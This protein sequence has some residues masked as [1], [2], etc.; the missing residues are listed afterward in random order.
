MASSHPSTT[1]LFVNLPP[2][3]FIG[4]NLISFNSS[5]QFHGIKNVPPGL[6]FIYT[7]ADATLSMRNGIWLTIAPHQ[8]HITLKWTPEDE[9][10]VV[11]PESIAAPPR[12]LIDYQTLASASSNAADRAS[13]STAAAASPDDFTSLSSHIT[14]ALITRILTQNTISSISTAPRDS[15]IAGLP[16]IDA[17]VYPD[18]TLGFLDID[19]Q[20]T[21]NKDDVGAIRTERARDRSWYLGYLMDKAGEGLDVNH[22]TNGI[23]E[24]QR[25]RRQRGAEFLLGELQFSF[26][27]VMMLANYSCL[28][29]WKRLLSVLLTCKT[30]LGEI[31]GYFVEVLDM[32]AL[33][34][35]HVDDVEG[36]LFELRDEVGSQW[37]RLLV[38]KFS[39]NVKEFGGRRLKKR[40]EEFEKLMREEFDWQE[41][42]SVVRR[43]MLEMED[44]ERVEVAMDGAD[45]DE[46]K[47]EYAP[48]VVE[49]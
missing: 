19:L 15:E 33:Q 2:K 7:G 1:L 37:L 27:M 16:H 24:E 47:G 20:R 21:W 10:L 8:P 23:A 49:M 28:E 39:E 34:L 13:T 38:E 29:Q 22:G 31:E 48:V 5:P 9:H 6:Y 11:F 40:M 42:G 45:E 32:L 35:R 41:K 46:E 14:P 18:S 26:L 36:G 4:T 25:Q 12:G 43:G 17:S 30:A 44:G 3:T